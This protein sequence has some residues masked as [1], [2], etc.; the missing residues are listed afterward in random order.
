MCII[1]TQRWYFHPTSTL[2]ATVERQI[3]QPH[4]LEKTLYF[5][6]TGEPGYEG[7]YITNTVKPVYK[8]HSRECE[9]V[10]FMSSCL[11]YTG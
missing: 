11:L 7:I 5:F 2:G 4:K 9:N 3:K 1:S 10:A 8:G 6:N